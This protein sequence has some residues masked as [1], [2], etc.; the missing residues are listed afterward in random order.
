MASLAPTQA[1]VQYIKSNISPALRFR[2][3]LVAFLSGAVTAA[4]VAI[5]AALAP[6]AAVIVAAVGGALTG[7]ASTVAGGLGA[8]YVDFPLPDD[9]PIFTEDDEPGTGWHG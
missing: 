8:V 9:H 1:V 7:L 5:T 6:D 2:L 3:Y 4:A